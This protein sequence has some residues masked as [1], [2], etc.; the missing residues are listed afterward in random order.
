MMIPWN[1][2][3]PVNAPWFLLHHSCYS[4][5][6]NSRL[7]SEKSII[8]AWVALS[9]WNLLFWSVHWQLL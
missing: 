6:W 2:L 5:M 1:A 3:Y 7:F 4:R 8:T 9:F